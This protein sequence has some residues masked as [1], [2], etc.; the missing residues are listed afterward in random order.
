M[1]EFKKYMHIERFGTTGVKGIEMGD[2]YVF[3]KI[4]GTNGSVWLDDDGVLQA[5]SRNRQLTA[6]H[7]N[8]CFYDSTR[9]EG[10]SHVLALLQDHPNIRFYGEWLVPHTLKTYRD[11]A[12]RKFYVFD[13]YNDENEEYV[14]FDQYSKVL[15]EY[16]IEYI[17]PI[18]IVKNPHIEKLVQLLDSNSY[19][20]RDG[21]G[22]GEGIVIKNYDFVNRFGKTIW[23]KIVRNEFKEK[24]GKSGPPRI[25]NQTAEVESEIVNFFLTKS[26]VDKTYAKIAIDGWEKKMIPKLLGMCYHDLV[27]EEIIQICRKY[28]MPQI[29]FKRLMALTNQRVKDLRP[30]LFTG[31]EIK[32]TP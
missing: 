9:G 32:N 17:Q 13:V 30:E 2:C 22:F 12:W 23:A 5:G 1:S 18:C 8:A 31:G 19:L 21:E 29:D 3:P 24:H 27:T 28:K 14:H 11:D 26:M 4:D 25:S 7:D 6:H 20:I 10:F 15:D 16:G